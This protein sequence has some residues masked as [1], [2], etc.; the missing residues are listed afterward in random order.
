MGGYYHQLRS[1][2]RDATKIALRTVAD[3]LSANTSSIDR[4]IFCTFSPEDMAV[5]EDLVGEVFGP[6]TS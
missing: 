5:Y 4:V 2:I 3:F 6:E 1:P